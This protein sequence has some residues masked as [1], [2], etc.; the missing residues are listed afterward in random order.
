MIGIVEVFGG[1]PC[2][3]YVRASLCFIFYWRLDSVVWTVGNVS[4]VVLAISIVTS[5]VLS[6]SGNA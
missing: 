4:M 5:F 2:G 1:G 6:C 3:E